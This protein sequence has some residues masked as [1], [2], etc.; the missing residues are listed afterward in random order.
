MKA[1]MML[2]MA[3]AIALG[4]ASP[5]AAD[6]CS[7]LFCNYTEIGRLYTNGTPANVY[8]RPKDG[9]Q[10]N[11]SC[12][13]VASNGYLTLKTTNPM[14]NEIYQLLVAAT[15][16]DKLVSIRIFQNTPDCEIGYVTLEN[17]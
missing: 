3:G 11:L 13:P 12:G 4:S 2:A 8:V 9:G 6:P 17:P 7:G 15:T 16:H 10:Q 14:F 5:A 1:M